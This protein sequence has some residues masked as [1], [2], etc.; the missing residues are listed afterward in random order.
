MKWTPILHGIAAIAGIAGLLS[1]IGAWIASVY[2][3]FLGLDQTHLFNDANALLLTSIAFGVGTL[4]HL[5]KE[6]S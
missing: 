5:K 6:K 3:T 1:L 4:I 2:G